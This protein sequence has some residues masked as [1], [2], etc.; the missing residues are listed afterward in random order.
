MSRQALLI[1]IRLPISKLVDMVAAGDPNGTL[2][3][4]HLTQLKVTVPTPLEAPT[5]LPRSRARCCYNLGKNDSRR[6]TSQR[7]GIVPRCESCQSPIATLE[8]L[9]C[10]IRSRFVNT[11]E[12]IHTLNVAVLTVG[13][14]SDLAGSGRCNSVQE[15][16][17][18]GRQR[19]CSGI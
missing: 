15:V 8:R 17:G 6:P 18:M 2:S 9:R 19:H 13:C 3:H 16:V 1:A 7:T 4:P 5:L 11:L 12:N 14:W 10:W